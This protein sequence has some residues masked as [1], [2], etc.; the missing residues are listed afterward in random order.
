MTAPSS[1]VWPH[2]SSD[3]AIVARH[4]AADT[5]LRN[6][7]QRVPRAQSKL[8]TFVRGRVLARRFFVDEVFEFTP[9]STFLRAQDLELERVVLVRLLPRPEP[10]PTRPP[11]SGWFRRLD[12][13]PGSP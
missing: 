3:S 6:R 4:V 8:P 9:H 13:P 10:D 5:S 11:A 2:D 12:H 7:D 1:P